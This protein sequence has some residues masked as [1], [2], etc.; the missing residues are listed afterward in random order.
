[1]IDLKPYVYQTLTN[2]LNIPVHYFYPPLDPELPCVSYYEAENQ[3]HAQAD[4]DEYLTSLAY[5]IDIW[6]NSALSNGE[7][8]LTID[9]AMSAAGFQRS[10]SHDLFEP[11]T[12]IHH[13]TM[14]YK[15]LSTQDGTLYQ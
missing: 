15:A 4:G 5:V 11:D 12:G 3:F 13:K 10:F 8:A 7:T 9:A 14:R 6:S 2:A 1:M